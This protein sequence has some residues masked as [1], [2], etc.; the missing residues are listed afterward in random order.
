MP[1]LRRIYTSYPFD[2][3]DIQVPGEPNIGDPGV[4][5]HLSTAPGFVGL[6]RT[7][8]P[9]PP[10]TGSP[11]SRREIFETE[12]NIALQRT[13]E[14]RKS[15][16]DMKAD[17]VDSVDPITQGINPEPFCRYETFGLLQILAIEGINLVDEYVVREVEIFVPVISINPVVIGAIEV[18]NAASGIQRV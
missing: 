15:F 14:L 6:P 4:W 10:T 13:C 7:L 1:P 16:A 18:S 3:G 2:Q 9:I 17:D 11:T 12:L 5:F 8:W